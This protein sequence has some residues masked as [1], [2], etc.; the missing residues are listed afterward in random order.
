MI[1]GLIKIRYVFFAVDGV[2]AISVRGHIGRFRLI[3][4]F[5]A[6]ITVEVRVGPPHVCIVLPSQHLLYLGVI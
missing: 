6:E 4:L 5:P 1:Y 2:V 3:H